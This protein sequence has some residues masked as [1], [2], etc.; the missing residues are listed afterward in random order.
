MQQPA[1]S[2][3]RSKNLVYNIFNFFRLVR[4]RH[5]CDGPTGGLDR[6]GVKNRPIIVDEEEKRRERTFMF[7]N[8]ISV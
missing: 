4:L 1:E 6:K 8:L 7:Q 2:R 5:I 3:E